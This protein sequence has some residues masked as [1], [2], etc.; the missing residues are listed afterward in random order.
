MQ[1]ET[2]APIGAFKCCFSPFKEIKTGKP[3]DGMTD[4]STNQPTDEHDGS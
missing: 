3:S 1:I 2:S 4:Q